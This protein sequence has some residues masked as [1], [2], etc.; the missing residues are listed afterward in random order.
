MLWWLRF[1]SGFGRC[2]DDSGLHFNK[3]FIFQQWAQIKELPFRHGEKGQV[4]KKRSVV[5]RE[6]LVGLKAKIMDVETHQIRHSLIKL[7]SHKMRA[8]TYEKMNKGR[9]RNLNSKFTDY[10]YHHSTKLCTLWTLSFYSSVFTYQ[11][12]K[13][14]GKMLNLSILLW[15]AC[16]LHYGVCVWWQ[17]AAQLVFNIFSVPL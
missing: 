1:R 17:T 3:I 8:S 12:C 16:L 13:F 10:D 11:K 7:L 2:W 14:F 5:S 6:G 15:A 9:M 4:G